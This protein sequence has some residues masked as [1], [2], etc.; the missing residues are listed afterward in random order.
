M[1]S[2]EAPRVEY[3]VRTTG[4][5]ELLASRS[6]DP[7][8]HCVAMAAALDA[9]AAPAPVALATMPGGGGAAAEP[10]ENATAAAAAPWPTDAMAVADAAMGLGPDKLTAGSASLVVRADG[11]AQGLSS[12]DPVVAGCCAI[13]GGAAGIGSG[14]G[15]EGMAI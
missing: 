3:V 13:M 15:A 7:V 14:G 12:G 10:L 2:R 8:A 1:M 4:G 9:A 11:F 5:G 6:L